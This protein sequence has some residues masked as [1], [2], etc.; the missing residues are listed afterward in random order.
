MSSDAARIE[1][2]QPRGYTAGGVLAVHAYNILLALPV[3]ISVLVVSVMKLGVLTLLIPFFTL[4]ASA[5]FLPFGLGNAYVARLVRTLRPDNSKNEEGFIVQMTLS[6]RLRTGFRALVEDADDVGYLTLSASELVFQGD[7]VQLSI[8]FDQIQDVRRQNIG[9][10]GLFV[11][12]RRIGLVI[13]GLPN[14]KFVEFTERSSWL[15]PTSKKISQ[16]LYEVL[17]AK[18]VGQS[19]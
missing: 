7:S 16:K 12:G 17:S 13:S 15:L 3:F 6:P 8:P 1:I 10:R 14:I 18:R 2:V 11:Y 9:L 5:F 4:A 19:C